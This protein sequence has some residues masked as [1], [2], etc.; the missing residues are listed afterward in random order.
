LKKHAANRSTFIPFHPALSGWTGVLLVK[1]ADEIRNAFGDRLAALGIGT[2]HFGIL[3]TLDRKGAI[4]QVELGQHM[5][6]DRAPMVQHI[7]FLEGLGLVERTNNPRDRRAHAI[8]LTEKGRKVLA[9]ATEIARQIETEFFA[10]LSI[11]QR[12]Q[13]NSLLNQLMASHFI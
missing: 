1:A 6:I 5:R 7:D 9:D 10:P 3:F 12:Q 8:L 13:L 2:K 4:S 11:E